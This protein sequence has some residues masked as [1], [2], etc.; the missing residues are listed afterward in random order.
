[1]SAGIVNVSLN[2]GKKF[3]SYQ[4]KRAKIHNND[5]NIDKL[6]V[7]GFNILDKQ[8]NRD[9]TDVEVTQ[10]EL[11]DVI[12]MKKTFGVLFKKYGEINNAINNETNDNIERTKASNPYLGKNLVFNN[13]Q[14]CYVTRQGVAKLYP[15]ID[16]FEK[17]S[18]KN[19]CPSEKMSVNIPWLNEY[20]IKGTI[21][22][23]N[24]PLISGT[25]MTVGQA[26]GYEGTNIYSTSFDEKIDNTYFGCYRNVPEDLKQ[27]SLVPKMNATNVI[28]NY[29]ASASSIWT[30]NNN[31]YGP[32]RAFDDEPSTFWSS[33]GNSSNLYDPRTGAYKGTNT[34]NIVDKSNNSKTIMG[35]SITLEIISGNG[36]AINSYSLL[37]SQDNNLFLTRSPNTWYLLGRA[38]NKW[39]EIDFKDNQSFDKN[40]KLFYTSNTN[41]YD[42]FMLVVMIVGNKGQLNNRYCLHIAD[43]KIIVNDLNQPPAMD[44][45]ILNIGYTTLDTCRKYAYENDFK[46]FGLQ[47]YNMNTGLSACVVANDLTKSIEYGDASNIYRDVPIWSTN[48]AGT[49]ANQLYLTSEGQLVLLDSNDGTIYWKSTNGPPQ[50]DKGG[51]L[52]MDTIVASYGLN[53]NGG[54]D[55]LGN[56]RP[57]YNVSVGN[58]TNAIKDQLLSSYYNP[59]R[60]NANGVK[61]SYNIYI[62][63]WDLGI[64]PAGGCFKDFSMAYSCGNRAESINIKRAG[65]QV[66]TINCDA[67]NVACTF[68]FTIKDDGNMI[69][70]QD[71]SGTNTVNIEIWTS[72]TSGKSLKSNPKWVASKSKLGN[73]FLK[74]GEGLSVGDWLGS[75]N[76]N[77]FL[78][79]EKD[80]NLVLYT[81]DS[82]AGCIK[83]NN[84]IYG[85]S[86]I[87]AIYQI[88][89]PQDKN[90]IGKF[91]YVDE[92]SNVRE[93]SGD[94]LTDSPNYMLF[95]D[96]NSPGNIIEELSNISMKDA[97]AACSK[98]NLCGGFLYD[99]KQ[100]KAWL[101]N[102]N[103]FPKGPKQ[104][105]P[106]RGLILAVKKSDVRKE[107]A[108]N[109]NTTDV[110]AS[111]LKKFIEGNPISKRSECY[112]MFLSQKTMLEFDKVKNE[113]TI[114]GKDLADKMETLYKKDKKIHE[115][116]GMNEKQFKQNLELYKNIEKIVRENISALEIND[117]YYNIEG[118]RNLTDDDIDG[119]L[120]DTELR[121]LQ[122]NYSYF[123]WTILAV[124]TVAAT[125]H[126]F[127]K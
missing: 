118:M 102:K 43:F 40:S 112:S 73:N 98:N 86:G 107:S 94:I 85:T 51:A 16:V 10:S 5:N 29:K 99:S 25:P 71:K 1:M 55:Y 105:I 49:S 87:N 106:E 39:Y 37:P 50:C 31:F 119:M 53:C 15:S 4:K 52:N 17:T 126:A 18:G 58:V 45:N 63:N 123:L 11:T 75:P 14:V 27:V 96:Y 42:A 23:T 74:T 121:V 2:Q 114:L 19:G 93:Y 28:D 64:D 69:L 8:Q 116:F 95:K 34:I 54:R 61:S 80:G 78:K 59:G 88:N 56:Y 68:L 65:G 32:W 82:R 90:Y 30:G 97:M 104:Y 48:T 124:G 44:S 72:N 21:I 35:E 101:K 125:I 108:C 127:R 33:G 12:N 89:N 79:L 13:N 76:G 66:A 22:P 103:I 122:E 9:I 7:E 26:C 120:T 62:N 67:N 83:Q 91:A 70:M 24:P 3:T 60:P 46:Y 47:D 6:N 117:Y 81:S 113:L 57:D 84:D 77:A 38:N 115:K 110:T 41:N 36:V 109:K 100:N 92:D 20:N 111:T